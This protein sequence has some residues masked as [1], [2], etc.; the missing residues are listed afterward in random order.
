MSFWNLFTN[1]KSTIV[2]IID[3][4]SA[5]VSGALVSIAINKKG[6]RQSN[7]IFSTKV[8]T[9]IESDLDYDRFDFEILKAIKKVTHILLKNSF[10]QPE[11]FV[12]FLTSPFLVSQTKII[13]YSQ[14][15]KFIFTEKILHNL[16]KKEARNFCTTHDQNQKFSLIES[17]VTQIKLDG[18]ELSHPFGQEVTNIR[19]SQFLSGSSVNQLNKIR[20]A[21]IS[22]SHNDLIEF[23]SYS[24]AAFSALRDN[25]SVHKNFIAI[26][27]D[28]ELTDIFAC[29]DG[30][31]LENISFPY[32]INSVLRDITKNQKTF[33]HEAKSQ[34]NL[35]LN[36]KLHLHAKNILEQ[37]LKKAGQKWIS[38]LS[39]ALSLILNNTILP[40][41]I[42]LTGDTEANKIFINWIK[43]ADFEKYTLSRNHFKTSYIDHSKLAIVSPGMKSVKDT[44]L[45]FESIF[46]EKINK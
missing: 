18:Y 7:I 5:Q 6:Q 22:Q 39:E 40:E 11:K 13:N 29:I 21:I 23:H 17:K 16:T 43:D 34:L 19:I 41:Q 33:H 12:C 8:A 24:F 35:Y 2:A 36:D 32:G 28:G 15:N 42:I 31:L 10:F 45:I 37:S 14:E 46:L 25:P 4:G 20:E 38:A 1:K 3:V 30:V 44:Y 26:D 9:G 27:I